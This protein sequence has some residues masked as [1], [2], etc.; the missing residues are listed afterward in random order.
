MVERSTE[1]VV[2]ALDPREPLLPVGAEEVALG[3]FRELEV[4]RNVPAV[5]FAGVGLRGESLGRVLPNRLEHEEARNDLGF[6]APHETVIAQA[7]HDLEEIPAEV[8]SADSLRVFERR[9]AG[10]D[11]E[12][13]EESARRRVEEVVAPIDG[14]S[15]C[16]LAGREIPCTG[17]EETEPMLEP[18]E[19]GRRGKESHTR[20]RELDGQREPVEPRADLCDCGRVVVGHL[21]SGAHR[22]CALDEQPHCVELR[23]ALGRVRIARIG[24]RERSHRQI[25]LARDPQGSAT[26]RQD[27]QSRTAS[28][29]IRHER[30]RTEDLLEVVEDE[31]GV[32]RFEVRD[33]PVPRR[34]W[35]PIVETERLDDGGADVIGIGDGRQR[36][37]GDAPRKLA[38]GLRG[39]LERESR[40]PRATG[41]GE[42]EESTRREEPNALGDGIRASDEARELHGQ[43]VGDGLERAEPRELFGQPGNHQLPHDL[44]ARQV[45]EPVGTEVREAHPRRERVADQRLRGLGQQH[46]SAV[47][48]GSD[49]RRAVHVVPDV[50]DP[51]LRRAHRRLARVEPDAHAHHGF[52]R[53]RVG[54]QVALRLDDGGH[55][56]GC[57]HEHVEEGVAL[58][59]DARPAVGIE[60]VPDDPSVVAEHLAPSGGAETL[61]VLGRVLDVREDE[62]ERAGGK[63][64]FR[65]HGR[66][67]SRDLRVRVFRGHD[68]RVRNGGRAA[69]RRR[70]RAGAV[71][72]V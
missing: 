16:L 39:D 18:S 57:V 45:L 31:K 62:G 35:D 55:R 53:E 8:R 24:Q 11:R 43:V 68:G 42:R 67:V 54:R 27:L 47:S 61:H 50:V 32:A 15:Q 44:G 60:R 64:S 38:G 10:K 36:D 71:Q 12:A 59:A 21:E 26:R 7:G 49:P 58:R 46:L 9:P 5:H 33:Q 63:R 70:R 48:R 51:R 29:K 41:A 19:N 17:L 69:A 28:E 52:V 14:A 1:V 56:L 34:D 25:L 2:L 13:G 72:C 3:G 4:A 40:L 20:R 66:Q 65:G 30:R 37:E 23:D 22:D 6:V